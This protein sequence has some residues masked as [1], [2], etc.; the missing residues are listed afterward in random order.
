MQ[1]QECKDLGVPEQECNNK[2]IMQKPFLIASQYTGIGAA[3][4]AVIAFIILR[5]KRG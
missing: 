1:L 3:T 2:T 5:G 4:A